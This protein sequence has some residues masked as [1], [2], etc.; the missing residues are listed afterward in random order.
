VSS[1]EKGTAFITEL[2]G[3]AAIRQITASE[4]AGEARGLLVGQDFD[5]V[6]INAPLRDESGEKLARQIVADGVSQAMLIVGSEH[7]D[8]VA[9]LCEDDGVL[10]VAKPVN[11]AA[12]RSALRLAGWVRD[13]L[14]HVQAENAQ[15][16]QKI[17][18][19]R[20]TDRAK[21]ILISHMNMSE[22]EAHRYIEKQ[23]MDMR[24]TKRA[25]AEAILRTYEN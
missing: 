3:E 4:S 11:R 8:A 1:S 24:A 12:F 14:R 6:V 10:A 16:R 20:I 2:L 15:L 7:Y 23:A 13:R 25:V 9:A 18:D 5:L 19:I 21:Y 17:E 22:K